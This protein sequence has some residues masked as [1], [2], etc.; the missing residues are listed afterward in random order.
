MKKIKIGFLLVGLMVSTHGGV[1]ASGEVD[2]MG[3]GRQGGA[4]KGAAVEAASLTICVGRNSASQMF[5]AREL[6]RYVYLRTGRLLAISNQDSMTG[7]TISLSVDP[8]LGEQG[9]SLK[10]EGEQT[11][12]SI[13]IRGGSDIAVL[14]GV[15]DFLE[16]L[17]VRFYLHGDV[18]PDERV[19][20]VLPD[21]DETRQP[22]F[23][24]RGLNPWGSHVEGFDLWGSDDWKQTV[25][26]MT[27]MRMNFIGMHCY[28]RE[29]TYSNIFYRPEP[30]VWVGLTEDVKANGEVEQSYMAHYFNA[31]R[32]E[33]GYIP[34]PTSEYEHGFSQW[35]DRDDWGADVMKGLT[36]TPKSAADCN[37]VFNRTAAMFNEAFTEA[38]RLGVKTCL[39]TE[40]PLYYP[41]ELQTRLAAKGLD[42]NDPTTR[43]LVYE[44]IFERIQRAHPLDYYW[45]WT[46]ESWTW[47]GNSAKDAQQ[48]VDELQIAHRALKRVDPSKKLATAGW[49]LGPASDRT[50]WDKALPEDISFSAISRRVGH[51]QLDRSF[52]LIEGRDTWAIPWLEDDVAMACPQLWV[53]R[54]RKDAADALA[55]GCEGL[56]GL[57][58]R[59]HGTSP[60]AKALAEA[61]WEQPW[62][63]DP[64]RRVTAES[65]KKKYGAIGGKRTVNSKAKISGTSV[66]A[67]Y[68]SCRY[69]ME[70]YRLDVP[71]GTYTVTLQFCEP[72]FDKPKKRV[73]DVKILGHPVAQKLDLYEEV[74]KFRAFD[75]VQKQ[76]RVEDEILYIEFSNHVTLACVSGIAIEGMTAAANQIPAAPFSLKVNC[77]GPAFNDYVAD[78]Q[79]GGAV[80][81]PTHRDETGPCMDFYQD[82]SSHSFGGEVAEKAAAIFASID[83][84]LPQTTGWGPSAGGLKPIKQPRE[85]MAASFNFVPR[86]EA[87]REEIQ[88][89]G[90][91]QRFDYWLNMFRYHRSQAMAGVTWHELNG[92]MKKVRAEKDGVKKRAL[93]EKLALPVYRQLLQEV[94]G[95]VGHLMACAETK[96]D[97]GTLINWHGKNLPYMLERT[98]KPLQVLLGGDLPDAVLLPRHYSGPTRIIVPTVRTHRLAGEPL[99]IPVTIVGLSAPQSASMHWRALGQGAYE[100]VALKHLNRGVYSATLPPMDQEDLEYYITVTD[101]RGQQLVWPAT[102]PRISQTLVTMPADRKAAE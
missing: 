72:Y 61:G 71:N 83:G 33:W 52:S 80:K 6:R 79:Q 101:G 92:V 55:Y 18:I 31:L 96:G 2:S 19:P 58:W 28:V 48:V 82:W 23:A 66:P 25:S 1:T 14:Y 100:S 24:L 7:P 64:E 74:G 95:M 102:A 59:T 3:G 76:V 97:I 40:A 57:T 99:N 22:L 51:S 90:N 67:I 84:R 91:R 4:G 15:Y 62:N 85:K 39:G 46:D 86:L 29:K 30:T 5:A 45:I 8:S 49:V 47:K 27:K 44:G 20:L 42:V 26:Q 63:P 12:K 88:G 68:Q 34:K 89:V 36:P 43:Q 21:V 53:G 70:A 78:F 54:T 94:S 65:L 37:E 38:R 41:K 93:A 81:T 56:M 32:H 75:L 60:Q 13:R 17:G 11:S 98:K 50:A 35:F 9:Y 73:F 69:G 87:L 16:R 10:S 77:G